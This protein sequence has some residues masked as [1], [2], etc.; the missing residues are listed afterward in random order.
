MYVQEGQRRLRPDARTA[1]F[2]IAT[3]QALQRLVSCSQLQ[4]EVCALKLFPVLFSLLEC[5]CERVS[6]EAARL[7]TRLWAPEAFLNGAKPFVNKT[8][9]E[10]YHLNKPEDAIQVPFAMS[11]FPSFWV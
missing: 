1:G 4:E 7:L 5:G 9:G 2:L 11:Q 8:T 3:L 10:E 6:M